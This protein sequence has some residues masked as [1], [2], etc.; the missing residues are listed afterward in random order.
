[1]AGPLFNPMLH[2]GP[3]K[4]AH[5]GMLFITWG[6]GQGRHGAPG[7]SRSRESRWSRPIAAVSVRSAGILSVP[8]GLYPSALAAQCEAAR[9]AGLPSAAGRF[10]GVEGQSGRRCQRELPAGGAP[11]PPSV[12]LWVS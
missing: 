8:S 5:C 6:Q 9:A 3:K 4:N 11:G 2:W 1:M 10:R 7:I 12:G